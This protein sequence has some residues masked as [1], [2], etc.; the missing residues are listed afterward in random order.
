MCD[1]ATA[2][3]LDW[4][5]GQPNPDYSCRWV[6]VAQPYGGSRKPRK[7]LRRAVSQSGKVISDRRPREN[8][9]LLDATLQ[10]MNQQAPENRWLTPRTA[11]GILERSWPIG[12]VSD[13]RPWKTAGTQ[14]HGMGSKRHQKT[15]T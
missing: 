7:L 1:M 11:V 2:S 3:L 14:W 6:E 4:A 9:G 10:F 5:R 13:L 12:L 8:H 15:L